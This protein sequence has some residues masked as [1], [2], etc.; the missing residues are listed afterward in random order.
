MSISS[1]VFHNHV[2]KSYLPELTYNLE[3]TQGKEA[4]DKEANIINSQVH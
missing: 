2:Y 1:Y 4:A 3:L